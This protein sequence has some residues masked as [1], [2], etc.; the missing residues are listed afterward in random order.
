[1]LD[2]L[3]TALAEQRA[4]SAAELAAYTDY[5]RT[6]ARDGISLE[7]V[8]RAWRLATRTLVDELVAAA[9]AHGVDDHLLLNL[10]RE[11]L[12]LVDNAIL[13]YSTG[14]RE[15]EIELA[16][17]DS[18]RRADFIRALLTGTLPPTE[19]RRAAPQFGLDTT[20]EYVTFKAPTDTSEQILERMTRP[21][22]C[23]AIADSGSPLV[24]FL[25]TIDG[26]SA[27]FANKSF[28]LPDEGL[29]AFGPAAPPDGLHHSFRVA[30]RTLTTAA[31]FGR[32]DSVWFDDLGLLPAVLADPELGQQF[33]R[34][35]IAPVL[36]ADNHFLIN[37]VAAYIESGM[38]VE[39]T[40]REVFVHPN[41]VRYRIDR[42]HRIA[43]CDL[44]EPHTATKVW[45]AI[46][47]ARIAAPDAS[48]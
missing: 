20:T 11:V 40:A 3:V 42:F 44:R 37:T 48:R 16:G 27:G 36:R 5:G 10:T 43:D 45:W 6:R 12:D 35:F 9:P 34:R 17:R 38:N 8:M 2:Q 25:T 32:T 46:Q 4:A 14:H 7:G 13:A 39:I 28:R 18:E 29:I 22:R 26:D 41:T 33:H 24:V 21:N 19:L 47:Y 1:M 30:C 15:V 23:A 31:V